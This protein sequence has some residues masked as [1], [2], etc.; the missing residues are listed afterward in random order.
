MNPFSAWTAVGLISASARRILEMINDETDLDEN[1]AGYQAAIQGQV[2]FEDVS[3]GYN[4][5]PVL[6]DISFSVE[7]GQTVAIVG[8]TG[9]GKTTL[10]RLINRIFDAGNGRILI[11]SR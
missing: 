8:Q 4:G 2:T 7:P 9:S 1:E 6:A 5:E 3:F 10:T 11:D